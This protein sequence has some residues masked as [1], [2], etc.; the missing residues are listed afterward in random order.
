MKRLFAFVSR[1]ALAIPLLI[2]P[3]CTRTPSEPAELEPEGR[4]SSCP[5]SITA[6]TGPELSLLDVRSDGMLFAAEVDDSTWYSTVRYF[7]LPEANL[8]PL[9]YA[10]SR[11]SGGVLFAGPTRERP[12]FNAFCTNDGAVVWSYVDSL[13][14]AGYTDIG[15]WQDQATKKW[16]YRWLPPE[17]PRGGDP[18]EGCTILPNT[19]EQDPDSGEWWATSPTEGQIL[20]VSEDG[21]WIP[22]GTPWTKVRFFGE[23]GE[24]PGVIE[25]AIGPDGFVPR[26]PDRRYHDL[27]P[28]FDC[29]DTSFVWSLIVDLTPVPE[30]V[31][32]A[33]HSNGKACFRVTAWIEGDDPDDPF[34]GC[35]IV[36]GSVKRDS[37]TGE[38]QATSP[39]EARLTRVTEEGVYLADGPWT[40]VRYFGEMGWL[41]TVIPVTLERRGSELFA[42]RPDDERY[43]DLNPGDDCTDT[44]FVWSMIVWST[45]VPE[46]VSIVEHPGRGKAYHIDLWTDGPEPG[47]CEETPPGSG[48]GPRVEGHEKLRG[49]VKMTGDCYEFALFFGHP[50]TTEPA[51]TVEREPDGAG[52]WVFPYAHLPKALSRFNYYHGAQEFWALVDSTSAVQGIDVVEQEP[53]AWCYEVL[54]ND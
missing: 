18:F 39:D 19:E 52:G 3:A 15:V 42:P 44:S 28:G 25:T 22:T 7:A 35:E 40:E 13:S 45:P 16:S 34:E 10:G 11:V 2:L 29:T 17:E 31:V 4:S 41:P 51:Q 54:R 30:G 27:N 53:G 12:L 50:G 36:P 33:R 24:L 38:W 48:T 47:E 8:E 43:V 5:E 37:L 6:D 1:F 49:S 26:P 32:V 23:R 20:R 9:E 46:G 14:A 21:L